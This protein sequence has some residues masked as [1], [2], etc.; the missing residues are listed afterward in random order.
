MS[1]GDPLPE[2]RLRRT[3][4][5]NPF[6]ALC[7]DELALPDGGGYEYHSLACTH[8]AVLVIPVTSSGL[9][10]V[11]RI[12]R[13]P[14]R[15]WLLEFPAGAIEGDESAVDAAA[16]ELREETGY[17]ADELVAI[18]SFHPLPGI[19]DLMVDVVLARGCE[20]V[21]EPELETLEWLSV[22][23]LAEADV[24][25]ATQEAGVSSF[26]TVGL[27]YWDATR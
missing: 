6:F 1:A 9:F 10:V 4:A 24:R 19:A 3:I 5:A 8:R 21:T 27:A 13:H 25:S 26:L 7:A 11:E 23:E 22:V 15:R 20:R 16:R 17:A 18:G 2:V 12:Y 14:I